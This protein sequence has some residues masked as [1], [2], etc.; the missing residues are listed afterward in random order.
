VPTPS[1]VRLEWVDSNSYPGTWVTFDELTREASEGA[2]LCFTAGY[3]IHE[4]ETTVTVAHSYT[5][6]VSGDYNELAG[7]ITIPK[8]AI[9][10]RET[11]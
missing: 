10:R 5:Q 2:L 6:K 11:L 9:R 7:A 4:S 3:L 1:L 8:V